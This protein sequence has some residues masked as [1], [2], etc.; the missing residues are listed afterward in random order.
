MLHGLIITHIT[1]VFAL[2]NTRI[3][4]YTHSYMAFGVIANTLCDQSISQPSEEQEDEERS[5]S[6]AA[7]SSSSS[8]GSSA[9]RPFDNAAGGSGTATP[10]SAVPR[11]A[12]RRCQRRVC[13]AVIQGLT[14]VHFSAQHEDLRDTSLMLVRLDHLRDTSTD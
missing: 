7:S 8:T 5:A 3:H 14:L 6:A 13:R 4:P 11:A 10:L 1:H 2:H 12:Q 9:G